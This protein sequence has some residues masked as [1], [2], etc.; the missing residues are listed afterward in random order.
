[1]IQAEAFVERARDLGFHWYAGVPCSFLTPFINY[2]IADPKL[3]YVSSA[4]EGDAVA[5][6]AG[7]V[8][9]GQ[10]GV[11]MMQNSGLGNAINPLTSLA[12]PFRM[13]L[14]LIVTLRGDPDLKDEPQHELMGRMTGKLL[15]KMDVPWEYFP[16]EAAEIEQVL[17]HADTYLQRARRPYGL[18][19]RKGSVAPYALP[20]K[21][22]ISGSTPHAQGYRDLRQYPSERVARADALH[23]IVELTPQD[24]TVVIGTT[25]YTGRELFAVADRANQFYMVGSMG[26]A[27]SLGLGLSLTRPDLRVVVVDGDGAALMRMGNFA[28]VGAYGKRNLIHLVLDNEVHE[29]TGAQATVSAGVSFARIAHACGYAMALE[30]DTMGLVDAL[31]ADSDAP[32]PRFGHL[33]IR[34]GTPDNLPRPKLSPPEVCARLMNHIGS[35]HELDHAQPG[36]V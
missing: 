26:C 22:A 8:L 36:H 34:P 31:L 20:A 9:G 5:T 24:S 28:T 19:M 29:S 14:L 25:G 23:R 7:A 13:P 33:K 1:M 21:Q 18:I 12:H 11:A 2:T 32:G 3:H 35:V 16:T 6:C 17:E 4:N 10:R 15:D 30:G 27:S